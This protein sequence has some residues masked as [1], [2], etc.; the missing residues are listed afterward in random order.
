MKYTM[1]TRTMISFS[2]FGIISLTSVAQIDSIDYFGQ[3]PP[4]NTAVKFA[5]GII[6]QSNRKEHRLVFTPDGN[7]CYFAVSGESPKIY[8]TKREN[9]TWTKQEVAPFS[10]NRNAS[11]PFLSANGNRLYFQQ[12]LIDWKKTDIW[13]VERTAS[14][15]GEPQCLPSPINSDFSDASYSETTDGTA[16]LNSFRS[17]KDDIWCF[18]RD[19]SQS[20]QANSLRASMNYTYDL[21]HPCISPDGS[22]IVFSSYGSSTSIQQLYISFNKG[23]NE[24]T[25]P[26][27]MEM[28]GAKINIANHSQVS[29]SLSP[30]GKFLFF[31]RHNADGEPFDIYWVSTSIIDTLRKIALLTVSVKN[32]VEQNFKL[33]PNPT[34]GQLTLSFGMNPSKQI[35]TE[36]Y[37]TQGQ[38]VLSKTINNTNNATLDLTGCPKGIYLVNLTVDGAIYNEKVCLE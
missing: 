33:F 30:D 34:N 10:I 17:D 9:N 14:G 38:M 4:G 31:S 2:L 35:I 3:T 11:F 1:K 22:Y 37:N 36:V 23:N 16:Y 19:S 7:E 32:T 24:W 26:V 15:W 18:S 8:Y 25:T 29:P 12:Y 27:T 5:T 6:S 13:Y 21:S 28:S 20:I